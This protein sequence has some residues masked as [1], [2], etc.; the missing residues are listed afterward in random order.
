M[1]KFAFLL[2]V[3]LLLTAC[4]EQNDGTSG[5]LS[6]KVIDSDQTA[7]KDA[8][9][10]IYSSIPEGELIFNGLT[11][12]KGICEVGRVLQGQYGY[13]VVSEKDKKNYSAEQYFQVIAGDKK[14]LEVN[15]FL[16]SGDVKIKIV[17]TSSAPIVGV[18]VALIP[19]PNYSNYTYYFQDLVDES[20]AIVKTNS[21]GWVEFK[22]MPS[23][24]SYS[25]LVYYNSE[26]YSYSGGN[27]HF[28]IDRQTV[29]S[30]TLTV[31][32]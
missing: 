20:Y 10:S 25:A 22:D 5:T 18:S 23:N 16:N 6:I 4:G 7:Y 17:N 29:R 26:N 15:P 1:K 12:V 11:D 24:K 21:E 14:V 28:Y 3:C 19:H 13:Y 2:I 9:V 8:Q 32:L 31:N 30:Y 27:N